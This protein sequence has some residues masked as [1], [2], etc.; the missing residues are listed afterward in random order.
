VGWNGGRAP[1]AKRSRLLSRKLFEVKTMKKLA[2]I[3]SFIV[4]LLATSGAHAATLSRQNIL[5]SAAAGLVPTFAA[6]AVGGDVVTNSDGKTLIHVK[7]A[8]GT[9][10][11]VT[12]TAQSATVTHGG[13]G[14][15][16]RANFAATLSSAGAEVILGP[17]PTGA[18][19]NSS[20][21]IVISYSGGGAAGLTIA[22]YKAVVP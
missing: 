12:V 17:F 6:V 7:N 5:E 21:Q 15:V 11:T 4:L 10:A 18:F 2:F 16:T 20:D 3:F 1:A 13:Y 9:S 19:N 22:A 14:T 8:S